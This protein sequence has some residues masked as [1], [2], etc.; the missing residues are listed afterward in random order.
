MIDKIWIKKENYKIKE[1]FILPKNA[2][3]Q[4][5]KSKVKKVIKMLNKKK[6]DIQFVSASENIAWLLNIRGQDSEFT[7]LPNAYLILDKKNNFIL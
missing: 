4:N 6:I 3:G 7:P 2:T 1:F 5:Y